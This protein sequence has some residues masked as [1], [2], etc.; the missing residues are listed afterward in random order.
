MVHST[1]LPDI[2]SESQ[3]LPTS[4]GF[5]APVGGFVSEYFYDVW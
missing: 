1:R 2:S 3:F 5:D 4:L